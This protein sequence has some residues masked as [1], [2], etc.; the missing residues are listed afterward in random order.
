MVSADAVRRGFIALQTSV[1]L[2]GPGVVG[3]SAN[4]REKNNL[5]TLDCHGL[6]PFLKDCCNA[7]ESCIMRILG[8]FQ[9]ESDEGGCCEQRNSAEV[10]QGKSA[11]RVA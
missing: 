8:M 2:V 4:K 5:C 10:D 6:P 11:C 3:K 9:I 1:P 7:V